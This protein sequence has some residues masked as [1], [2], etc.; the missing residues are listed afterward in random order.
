MVGKARPAVAFRH[1]AA[2][3]LT[4]IVLVAVSLAAGAWFAVAIRQVHD[5]SRAA[6]LVNSHAKFTA[7]RA[8]RARQLLDAA[9]QLNPDAQPDILRAQVALRGGEKGAAERILERVV[10]REPENIDAWF[11]LQIAT[12]HYDTPTNVHAGER[13][14]QLAGHPRRGP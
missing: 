13:V 8:A 11:L 5:Q 2:M 12:F 1:D 7:P 10:R 9:G 3:P 6:S 4:R 14:R